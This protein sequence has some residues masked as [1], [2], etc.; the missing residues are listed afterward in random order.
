MKDSCLTHQKSSV[1]QTTSGGQLLTTHTRD[2]LPMG[3]FFQFSRR[4]VHWWTRAL[5]PGNTLYCG[6]AKGR[7]WWDGTLRVNPKLNEDTGT[8]SLTWYPKH[9]G[10]SVLEQ[11]NNCFA[12][13]P[14]LPCLCVCGGKRHLGLEVG[15]GSKFTSIV[16]VSWIHFQVRDFSWQH[17]SLTRDYMLNPWW[18]SLVVGWRV[19][20]G[21][22]ANT[23]QLCHFVG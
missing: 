2:T 15:V 23:D 8:T 14:S 9:F 6:C 18:W 22:G 10:V 21:G 5:L 12:V 20:K 4:D 1:L 19:R 17:L 3:H 11:I 16:L 13:S 7:R